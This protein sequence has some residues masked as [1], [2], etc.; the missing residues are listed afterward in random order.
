MGVIRA[1][2]LDRRVTLL[3]RGPDIDDGMGRAPG[4]WL[5]LGKRWASIKPLW[6]GEE[7]ASQGLSSRREISVWL[8]L[9]VKT[10][11][12]TAQDALAI[13]GL[14]Y[15]LTGEPVMVGRRE[16]IE[17]RAMA[18]DPAEP[19]VPEELEPA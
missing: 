18:S 13:D 6:R 9:D 11:T 5:R 15:L 16:A 1:G 17:L 12:V 2:S 19:I 14:I 7:L 10:R 8:R 4:P 3:R